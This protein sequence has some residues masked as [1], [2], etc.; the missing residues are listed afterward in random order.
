[1][2]GATL[3]FDQLVTNFGLP[4]T[5][6]GFHNSLRRLP[7]PTESSTLTITVLQIAKEY[8]LEELHRVKNCV[9]SKREA[10]IPRQTL[11][12]QLPYMTIAED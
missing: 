5:T 9:G 2:F 8:K 6:L 3:D 11:P 12:S 1:M 10:F 4:V 7:E